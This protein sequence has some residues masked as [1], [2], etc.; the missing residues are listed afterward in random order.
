MDFKAKA[1]NL[2]AL[3]AFLALASYFGSAF[4]MRLCAGGCTGFRQ[5]VMYYVLFYL[6]FVIVAV[7]IILLVYFIRKKRK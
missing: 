7:Y 1:I 4:F 6:A 3:A 2:G 5:P